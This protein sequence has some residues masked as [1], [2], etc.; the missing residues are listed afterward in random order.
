[1]GI[2]LC[3]VGFALGG[4]MAA[5]SVLLFRTTFKV[6]PKR[7]HY[8]AIIT[9]AAVLGMAAAV[10][11]PNIVAAGALFV[12]FGVPAAAVDA[13]EHRVPDRLTASLAVGMAITLVTAA[14]MT[15]S[16]PSLSRALAGAVVWGGL[17]FL[18]YLITGD[19]G[20]GDVK[21]A[22]SL[23]MLLGWL[24]WKW[25]LVGIAGAYLLA[26]LLGVL[27]L[28]LMHWSLRDSRMPLAPP[29]L[30][31]TVISATMAAVIG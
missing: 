26:A 11:P 9:A 13:V 20:P 4:G 12:V 22:P 31:A 14:L 24:G 2:E 28:L 25:L 16:A 5:V 23:G 10:W 19:P 1:M 6:P 18:S 21:L 30:A 17:L 7:F 29:M 27:G 15:D 3:V 8:I